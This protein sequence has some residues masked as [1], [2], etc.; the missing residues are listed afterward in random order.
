[1]CGI[2]FNYHVL[3]WLLCNI[4]LLSTWLVMHCS[5]TCCCPPTPVLQ[6]AL[7]ELDGALE[8]IVFAGR[9]SNT[10]KSHSLP[11]RIESLAKRAI[12]W[13][14]LRKKKNA[15][16]KLAITVFSFPPDKG[17]V[18]TAAYLNV[19]GSIFA[20]LKNL[21]ACGYDVG[22]LPNNEMDLI[23][24]RGEMR[25]GCCSSSDLCDCSKV[26]TALVPGWLVL[27][28]QVVSAA[29]D[30]KLLQLYACLRVHGAQQA[31]CRN[32]LLSWRL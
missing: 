9:D 10:G 25:R 29:V 11:D 22:S 28:A 31:G 14:S 20:V 12:N 18:G 6:V 19:F 24:V 3:Q 15:D 32:I 26:A 5:H 30:D 13:A 1:M 4:A 16:K 23:Q 7:P 27:H 2:C 8:P 21:K 17:N